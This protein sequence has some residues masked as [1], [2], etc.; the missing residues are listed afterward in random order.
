MRLGI[1]AMTLSVTLGFAR[2]A[3]AQESGN[4]FT[5]L[6]T[7]TPAKTASTDKTEVKTDATKIPISSSNNRLTQ[8]KA[9]LERRQ[10]VCL[11]LRE[12]AIASGDDD[13]LRKAEMLDQRAY[14]LYV[15]AKNQA[16]TPVP[17]APSSD[18]KKGGR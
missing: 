7:P 13:L 6:F 12:I 16:R 14:D 8:A 2:L 4:W 10:D 1:A 5:R 3:Y 15:A 17:T 18:A 9:D 11:K